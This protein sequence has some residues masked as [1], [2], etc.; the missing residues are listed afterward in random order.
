MD[1]LQQN[2][3]WVP[4]A[5]KSDSVLWDVRENFNRDQPQKIDP[6]RPNMSHFFTEIQ[7]E[8]NDMISISLLVDFCQDI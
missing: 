6:Y 3:K 4:Y 7:W 1:N 2:S 5:A 8:Y